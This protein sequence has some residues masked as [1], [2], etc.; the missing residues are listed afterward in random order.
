MKKISLFSLVTGLFLI[1]GSF[2]CAE[3]P[4]TNNAEGMPPLYAREVTLSQIYRYGREMYR[5]GNYAEAVPAFKRMITFD[6]RNA[7]AHY[8][9]QQISKK[10]THFKDLN[11]YLA[12]LSCKGYDFMEEDF[13][14]AGAL[15][16]NDAALLQSQLANYSQRVRNAKLA[17]MERAKVYDEDVLRL[18]KELNDISKALLASRGEKQA[19]L[20]A[21]EKLNTVLKESQHMG[22]EILRLQQNIVVDREH[23]QTQLLELKN[24]LVAKEGTLSAD[25]NT[26][27]VTKEKTAAAILT[28]EDAAL[29]TLQD[30]FNAI[31]Q[32]LKLIEASIKEKNRQLET[33]TNDLNVIRN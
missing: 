17:L 20:A 18:E 5:A 7:L 15:Y 25:K 29:V 16:E 31:Q 3:A 28:E 8:H 2:S 23:Y 14:P 26:I 27:A 9:L 1:I 30:K 6:C 22:D 11:D 13:L 32:R 21:S 19:A 10:D 33:L 4:P 24:A 12:G